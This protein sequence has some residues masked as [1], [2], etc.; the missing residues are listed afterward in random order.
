MTFSSVSSVPVPWMIASVWIA[1]TL[2]VFMLIGVTVPG[3]WVLMVTVCVVPTVILLRLWNDGPPPTIAE[4]LR[5]TE[6]HR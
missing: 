1:M 3:G 6:T 4:V 2:L 5:A